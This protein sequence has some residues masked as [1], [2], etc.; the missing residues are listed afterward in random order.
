MIYIGAKL[1]ARFQ[2]SVSDWFQFHEFVTRSGASGKKADVHVSNYSLNTLIRFTSVS[3]SQ[4]SY[5]VD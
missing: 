4:T 3:T 2:S 5:F 1:S